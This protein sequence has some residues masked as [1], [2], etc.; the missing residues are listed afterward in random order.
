MVQCPPPSTLSA[1]SDLCAG[2]CQPLAHLRKRDKAEA[3][4]LQNHCTLSGSQ[5]FKAVLSTSNMQKRSCQ[6]ELQ[7]SAC[8]ELRSLSMHLT[9]CR[10]ASMYD[11]AKAQQ[12][13]LRN[14]ALLLECAACCVAV[15][16]LAS[17]LYQR[18]SHAASCCWLPQH[19]NSLLGPRSATD[20]GSMLRI[21]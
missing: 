14:D 8:R 5:H 21:Q 20:Q 19:A 11:N 18:G 6:S 15:L 4:S 13:N 16:R 17:R 7:A 1:R 10:H 2:L 3:Q 12:Q 9:T